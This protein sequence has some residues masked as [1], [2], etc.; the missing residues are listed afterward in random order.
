MEDCGEKEINKFYEQQE[1]HPV[2]MVIVEGSMMSIH[3]V[4]AVLVCGPFEKLIFGVPAK[5][6]PTGKHY[7][8]R[9]GED[10]NDKGYKESWN[11]AKCK[12]RHIAIV[13]PD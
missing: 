9:S 12:V 1:S 5:Y 3:E 4:N 13:K 11:V 2:A 10:Y 6:M 7:N 8:V